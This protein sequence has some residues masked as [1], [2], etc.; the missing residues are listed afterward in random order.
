MDTKRLLLAAALSALVLF[1]WSTLFPPEPQPVISRPQD[2]ATSTQR[3]ASP[4][5]A[6]GK[7]TEPPRE[8]AGP[9]EY[10]RNQPDLSDG[11]DATIDSAAIEEI[12]ALR[13]EIQ[14]VDTERFRAE[15]TNRGGQLTSFQLKEHSNAAGGWVELV[16]QRTNFP[17]P[18]A[19]VDQDGKASE[20]SRVLFVTE[21]QGS[22]EEPQIVFRYQG[23]A[24]SALKRFKFRSDGLFDV[25]IEAHTSAP[26]GVLLGPGIGNPT[27]EEVSNRFALRSAIYRSGDDIER[28]NVQRASQSVTISGSGLSWLGMEDRYF[29][30]VLVPQSGLREASFH[31]VLSSLDGNGPQFL[32]FP[33]NG[34]LNGDQKDLTREMMVILH[35]EGDRLEVTGFWGAKQLHRLA[36]LPINLEETVD[37]GFFGFLARPLLIGL[38]WIHANVVQNFGWAIILMTILIR[39]V[40]FPLTHKSTVSMQKMQELNPKV[41][42]VK[43]KYRGKLKDKKGRPNAEAQKKMNEEVMGIYRAAGVN[44]AGGCFPMLLQIPVLFAFYRLLSSAI[45]LRHAPWIFWIT[46]LSAPDPIYFLPIVMGASQF[47]QQR[48]TPSTGDPMQRRIFLLMPVFFTILFL[49]FPSGLVLYWLTNNVLGIIQQYAYKRWREKKESGAAA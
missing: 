44:P 24:G 19:I 43:N 7:T 34:D 32:L 2:Q 41:Q 11:I 9:F 20:L 22:L 13:E 6:T 26:W 33:S 1:V 16:H 49:G 42:A 37:L 23:Q 17:Y 35:P 12:A 14:V 47:I 30:T 4:P 28:I 29:L 27:A 3:Q 21:S 40:L 10:P 38:R 46:D 45:E 39:S 5:G 36:A 48:M 18:F 31:P 25:E 15:F 8:S